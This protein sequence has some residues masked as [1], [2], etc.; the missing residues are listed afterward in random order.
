MG[1]R[2]GIKW[3]GSTWN[4]VTGC[5]KVSPGCAYCYAETLSLRYGWSKQPWTPQNAAE[6]VVL[7][8]ERL[9]IPLRWREPRMIFV[10]SMSDLFHEQVPDEFIDQVFAVMA[11]TPWHIYQ[12]L[13]KRP[14]RMLAY[15]TERFQFWTVDHEIGWN[16]RDE[17]VFESAYQLSVQLARF[18]R[19]EWWDENEKLK[20]QRTWPLPNVWLGVT[21]ENQHFLNERADLLLKTPAAVRFVSAEPLLGP[22]DF[23]GHF[24]AVRVVGEESQGEVS[25]DEL[26][27][28]RRAVVAEVRRLGMPGIDWVIV[29]GESAG[30]ENRR[31][32]EKFP[33]RW[34]KGYT[35]RPTERAKAW[36]RS[37]R[38][39]C[40]EAGVA[41]FLKQWG[42]PRPDSG[43][44]YLDGRHYR[45]YPEVSR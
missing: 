15:M 7:H 29:G 19:D 16:G 27:A 9:Q 4:P 22:L 6:N 14:E 31:L 5:S 38:D 45:E 33:E 26:A 24:R 42:G 21:C 1:E 28:M 20:V 13:T 40:R 23:S 8:P 44:D 25:E 36:V 35:W 34:R 18:D 3:T 37:I 17:R 32:V 11:L 43:L 10:N 41:F 39:Q 2:T 12:V 30:P